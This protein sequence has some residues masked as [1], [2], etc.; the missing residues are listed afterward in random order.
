MFAGGR[1]TGATRARGPVVEDAGGAPGAALQPCGPYSRRGRCRRPE[2]ALALRC[3]PQHDYDLED[4]ARDTG[5]TAPPIHLPIYRWVSFWYVIN[6]CRELTFLYNFYA[7][8]KGRTFPLG[9][10]KQ[11]NYSVDA[12]AA[13]LRIIGYDIDLRLIYALIKI[14]AQLLNLRTNC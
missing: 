13:P 5:P 6:S 2:G 10:Q 4:D 11:L 9:S 3:R 8:L 7:I 12:S 14:T 1:T